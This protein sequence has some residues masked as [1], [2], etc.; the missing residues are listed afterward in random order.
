MLNS[1]LLYIKYQEENLKVKKFIQRILKQGLEVEQFT[2]SEQLRQHKSKIKQSLLITD[3][4][5]LAKQYKT[6]GYLIIGYRNLKNTNHD[7]SCIRYM[8]E[9]FDELDET[10]FNYVYSRTLGIPLVVL[11]TKRCIVREIQVDDLEQLYKLYE[12]KNVIAYIED[13]LEDK[14]AEKEY[15][16]SYQEEIYGFYD[17]GMWIIQEIETN[18][19]IGRAGIENKANSKGQK[20]IELGYF[21]GKEF[22][23]QG[24]GYEVCREII[25][26]TKKEE[27]SKNLFIYTRKENIPSIKLCKKLGFQYVEKRTIHNKEYKGYCIEL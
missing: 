14:E 13:L 4:M 20:I 1:I 15:I 22:Q 17:Y 2:S 25:K 3:D 23:G 21:I 6:N 12:D 9:G 11:K 24:Y 18:Q 19:I 26:Y 8:I 10:Y 27:I 7:F 16:K 5:E